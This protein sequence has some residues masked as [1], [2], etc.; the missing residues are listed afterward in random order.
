MITGNTKF[1]DVVGLFIDES[2]SKIKGH[3]ARLKILKLNGTIYGWIDVDDMSLVRYMY[4]NF[5]VL[6]NY[7]I[8]LF[9]EPAELYLCQ[10]GTRRVLKSTAC[11]PVQLK[12]RYYGKDY[13]PHGMYRDFFGYFDVYVFSTEKL[14]DEWVKK[15]PYSNGWGRLPASGMDWCD[16]IAEHKRIQI[17]YAF[18]YCVKVREV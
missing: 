2:V 8:I 18:P 10:D 13:H 17:R 5:H 15:K 16:D 1:V 9:D 4:K 7:S 11:L 12:R 14:R 6:N 3:G